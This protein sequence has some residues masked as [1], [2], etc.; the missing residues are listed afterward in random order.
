MCNWNEGVPATIM[1]R[2]DEEMA[3]TSDRNRNRVNEGQGFEEAE[4]CEICDRTDGEHTVWIH[5]ARR[6]GLRSRLTG[7]ISPGGS[8]CCI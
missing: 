1:D 4:P 8:G 3:R 5:E 2:S 6:K 7:A